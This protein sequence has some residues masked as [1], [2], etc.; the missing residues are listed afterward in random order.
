[1][2]KAHGEENYDF[3]R[4][5]YLIGIVVIRWARMVGGLLSVVAGCAAGCEKDGGG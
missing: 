1:M 4:N 5:P 3:E 2:L